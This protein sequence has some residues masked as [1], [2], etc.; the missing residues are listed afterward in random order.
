MKLKASR[1]C[2]LNERLCQTYR[3]SIKKQRHY[4]ADKG[5]YS[6]SY[7]FSSSHVQ[8]WEL[9][10]KKGQVLKYWCF[11]TVV[12]E[13]TPESPLDC[14]EIKP[15]NPKGNQ[16]WIYH[17]KD[18][19]WSSNTLT[20]WCE[21]PTHLEKTLILGKIEGRRGKGWWRTRWL[22]DNTDSVCM[23]LSEL[24]EM[25]KDRETW[26]AAVHRVTNSWTRLRDWTT[27]ITKEDI[28]LLFHMKIRFCFHELS[29]NWRCNS[30]EI[31]D[32]PG[33]RS[34]CG[35]LCWPIW[36]ILFY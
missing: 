2:S 16:P 13:K 14:K 10:H 26:Q 20:S 33:F 28:W 4:C 35:A 31:L 23:S 30:P 32:Y 22:D 24:Q 8:M 18:W 6:Q 19:C 25:V 7:G 27:A 12:L 36:I 9:E 11:Q 21:E 17:W 15:I 29:M 3:Q 5:P 34:F 1:A